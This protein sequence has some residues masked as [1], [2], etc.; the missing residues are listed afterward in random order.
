MKRSSHLLTIETPNKITG[1]NAGGRRQLH[2]DAPGETATASTNTVDRYEE[3]TAGRTF[4]Q[5]HGFFSATSFTCLP[6][7]KVVADGTSNGLR[8]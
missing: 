4:H 6:G 8:D 2:V 1:A 3:L 5:S 7:I